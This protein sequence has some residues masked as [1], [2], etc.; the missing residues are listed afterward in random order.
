[1][2]FLKD[3]AAEEKRLQKAIATAQGELDQIY[4]QNTEVVSYAYCRIDVQKNMQVRATLGSNDGIQIFLNGK[5]VYQ[6]FKKRSLIPDE[7][8]IFLDLVAGKNHLLLKIDQ[9]KGGWGFSFR[10]PDVAVR[11][12]KQKYRIV[13]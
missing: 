4:Q 7:D 8:E 10:L 11:N 12:H 1:M 3:P 5:K 9:N 2:R 13:E 6:N